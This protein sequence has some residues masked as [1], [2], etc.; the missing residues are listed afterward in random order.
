[1]MQNLKK[2][3]YSFTGENKSPKYTYTDETTNGGKTSVWNVLSETYKK[4]ECVVWEW[5]KDKML[6]KSE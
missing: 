6:G 4:K 5:D 3:F 1:M 2:K